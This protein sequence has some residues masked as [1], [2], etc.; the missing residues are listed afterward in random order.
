VRTPALAVRNIGT[1]SAT[2]SARSLPAALARAIRV[3]RSA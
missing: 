3:V 2:K 1:S